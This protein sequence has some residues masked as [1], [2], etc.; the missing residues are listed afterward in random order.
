MRLGGFAV[1]HKKLYRSA[2]QKVL[3]GVCGGLAEYFSIDVTVVRLV[4]VL[5]LFL[6]GA[7]LLLYIIAVILI[8]KGENTDETGNTGG[9]AGMDENGDETYAP[10]DETTDTGA[11]NNSILF[12][13]IILIVLGGIALL[14]KIFPFH[15]LWNQVKEYGWPILLIVI[16]IL[17]LTTSV[18]RKNQP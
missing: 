10:D 15:F 3:A 12:I 5:S 18:R 6:G 8:P 17:I 13:G 4:W 1:S 7:G 11:R 9:T 14:D 2:G 16:G